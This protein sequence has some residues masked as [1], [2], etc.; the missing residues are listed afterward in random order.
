[1]RQNIILVGRGNLAQTISERTA[2]I[3]EAE[4]CPDVRV[5]SWEDAAKST[6]GFENDIAVHV[7]SGRELPALIEFCEKNQVPLIQ[8]SVGPDI[9]KTFKSTSPSF[10]YIEAPN[11]SLPIIKLFHLLRDAGTLFE[12]CKVTIRESHQST[13]TTVPGTAREFARLLRLDP[14]K[15]VSV[16]DPEVQKSELGVP[17]KHLPGHAIHH[18]TVEGKGGTVRFSTEVLGRDTYV[19]GIISI[20]KI[21]DR[22]EPRKYFITELVEKNLV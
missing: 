6:G 15:I 7:G 5:S 8:G 9:E 18:I 22:L 12:G 16:R 20:M 4:K 19:Y 21:V 11:L 2:S 17:E 13:K 3:A 10:S 1:M 14:D